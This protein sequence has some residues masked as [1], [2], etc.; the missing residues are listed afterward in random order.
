M[1]SNPEDKGAKRRVTL[2]PRAKIRSDSLVNA[3][4]FN[5][6]RLND[7]T[8]GKDSGLSS[9]STTPTG[10]SPPPRQPKIITNFPAASR[11]KVDPRYPLC[12]KHLMLLF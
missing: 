1:A 12:L 3:L 11:G 9:E 10:G 2:I 8:E 4:E 5:N 7:H 6:L